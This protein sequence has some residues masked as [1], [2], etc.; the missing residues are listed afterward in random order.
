MVLSIVRLTEFFCGLGGVAEALRQMS[1]S[2]APIEIVRAIDIDRDCCEVYERNFGLAVDRRSVESIDFTTLNRS[3]TDIAAW[4]LSPPCQ[5]YCRR[6]RC[7]PQRDRRCDGLLAILRYL[8]Q[9]QSVIPH[10]LAMENVPEF[11]QSLHCQRLR[12]ALRERGFSFW[13]GL[14][15]ATQWG[16]PNR[17]KRFYLIASR[18]RDSLQP[19]VVPLDDGLRFT[20]GD[21]LQR[22]P[23]LLSDSTIPGE[24]TLDRGIATAY[25]PALDIVDA[26]DPGAITACFAGGYGKS[27]VRSGSYLETSDSPQHFSLRRFSPCEVAGLLGFSDAFVFPPHLSMRRRW[28]L[29]GNSVSIPVVKA[30]LERLADPDGTLALGES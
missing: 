27:I 29:L 15:C 8:E 17:R 12:S 25:R 23:E 4:W 11:A 19:P 2:V 7:S 3:N 24:L 13:E 22:E 18:D 26:Q 30:I 14:L 16:V 20:V 28:K 5:P 10:R 21:I 1:P 9:P 6:G